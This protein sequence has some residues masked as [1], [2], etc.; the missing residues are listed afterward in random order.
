MS[1]KG[2]RP[3]RVAGLIQAELGRLLVEEFQGPGT[4]FLSV[5]RVEMTPD[6]LA[7][8]VF[9][10]VFGTDDPGALFARVERSAGRIRRVLA[11]RVKLKY[12][13]QLFFAPDPGPG[14]EAKI[15]RLIEESKKHGR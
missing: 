3:R 10:S 12:N 2:L 6:L 7:A 15:D 1:E 9:L 4:G 14:H 13:P 5:T 11:S 8:R